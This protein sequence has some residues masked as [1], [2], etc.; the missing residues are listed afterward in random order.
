MGKI[1]K[2]LQE[3]KKKIQKVEDKAKGIGKAV[4]GKAKYAPLIPFAPMMWSILTAK[5]Y[6]VGKTDLPGLTES[7]YNNVVKGSNG[8]YEDEERT[9]IPPEAIELAISTIIA[10][11]KRIKEKKAAGKK[12]TEEEEAVLDKAKDAAEKIEDAVEPDNILNKE[13]AGF[14]IKQIGIAIAVLLLL[15]FLYK[16]Y[17]K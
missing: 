16:K 15:A 14:S 17:G 6:K 1:R 11:V 10:F 2:K 8:N 9:V 7:F 13:I 12:L 4:I 5:G 3:A